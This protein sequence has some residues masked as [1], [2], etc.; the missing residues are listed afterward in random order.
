[1][2]TEY[3]LPPI[4]AKDF[5]GEPGGGVGFLRG[6][7]TELGR[8]FYEPR[9]RDTHVRFATLTC[10]GLKE[11]DL[12]NDLV[13]SRDQF[14]QLQAYSQAC[15]PNNLLFRLACLYSLM[16]NE[17]RRS[18]GN[19]PARER[20][21]PVTIANEPVAAFRTPTAC[22]VRLPNAEHGQGYQDQSQANKTGKRPRQTSHA[23]SYS[24][25]CYRRLQGLHCALRWLLPE[26]QSG[27]CERGGSARGSMQL[28]GL[29][30]LQRPPRGDAEIAKLDRAQAAEPGT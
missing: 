20:N 9:L 30:A 29:A 26:L 22:D 10:S 11:I 2:A 4:P 28:A 24:T 23:A 3:R 19:G 14:L 16:G 8:L 15:C 6:Q 17:A 21:Q 25:A 18:N 5:L 12:G 13:A 7:K 1:M 27:Y